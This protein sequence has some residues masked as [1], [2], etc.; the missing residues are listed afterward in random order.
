MIPAELL[1][2][3]RQWKSKISVAWKL[4]K[5]EMAKLNT[6]ISFFEETSILRNKVCNRQS[7]TSYYT[8][9]NASNIAVDT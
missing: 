5:Q 8:I 1:L 9:T 2:A 3:S 6:S 4:K 7:R